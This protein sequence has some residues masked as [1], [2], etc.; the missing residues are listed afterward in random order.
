MLFL[1]LNTA[2]NA[3]LSP[4]IWCLEHDY[5]NWPV[6]PSD[7]LPPQIFYQSEK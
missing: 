2:G 7:Q 1:I 6:A 4:K 5:V 3:I